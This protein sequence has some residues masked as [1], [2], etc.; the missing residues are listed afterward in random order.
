M[1]LTDEEGSMASYYRYAT[2]ERWEKTEGSP[3]FSTI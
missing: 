3:P 1:K 2:N